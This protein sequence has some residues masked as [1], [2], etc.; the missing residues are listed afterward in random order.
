MKQPIY[1]LLIIMLVLSCQKNHQKDITKIEYARGM[2]FGSCIPVAISVDSGLNYKFFADSTYS[3]NKIKKEK[4]NYTGTIDNK[5]WNKL[6]AE[7][8]KADYTIPDTTKKVEMV[9]AQ[10]S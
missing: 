2:C 7:L 3:W 1:F 8:D 6:I 10:H 9:D 5:L 4:A